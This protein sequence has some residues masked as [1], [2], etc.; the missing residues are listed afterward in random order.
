MNRLAAT[1]GLLGSVVFAA[2]VV[3]HAQTPTIFIQGRVLAAETGD[4]LPHARVVI[5]ND[6]TPL[7]AIFSDSQGRFASG[8]LAQSRYHVVVTK[9]GY[10]LTNITGAGGPLK[11]LIVGS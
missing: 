7:P 5:Y 3:G 10:A 11:I 2:V 1:L 8:P 6:A 4:A 9:P